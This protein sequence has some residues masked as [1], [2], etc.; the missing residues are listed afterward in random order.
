MKKLKVFI[1]LSLFS[2][3]VVAQST[4]QDGVLERVQLLNS[5]IFGTKD[6]ATL[7]GL[8]ASEVT[9][10]HSGGKIENRQEALTHATVNGNSY[11]NTRMDGFSVFFTDKKT[12][13]V[14]YVLYCDQTNKDGLT[15][16]KLSMLQVWVKQKGAWKLAARQAVKVAN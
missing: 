15:N 2:A 7:H 3:V 13:I 9:Y 14:R 16:L 11:A 1:L 6:S 10:G 8:L 4:K 12:A 5:T